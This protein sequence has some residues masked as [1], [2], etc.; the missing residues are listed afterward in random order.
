MPPQK[1]RRRRPPAALPVSWR[2]G[3]AEQPPGIAILPTGPQLLCRR[4]DFLGPWHFPSRSQA[5]CPRSW[6]GTAWSMPVQN[7]G[8]KSGLLHSPKRQWCASPLPRADNYSRDDGNCLNLNRSAS[9][10]SATTWSPRIQ[11]GGA[12]KTSGSMAWR[13]SNL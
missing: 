13:R 6:G 10:R 1:L 5:H 7:I 2:V 4:A 11:F 12:L 9:L 8:N 3:L